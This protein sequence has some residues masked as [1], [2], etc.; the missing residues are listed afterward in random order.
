[1]KPLARHFRQRSTPVDGQHLSRGLRRD[2]KR[3]GGRCARPQDDARTEAA[4]R[5]E[6]TGAHQAGIDQCPQDQGRAGEIV[7][8]HLKHDGQREEMRAHDKNDRRDDPTPVP[9]TRQRRGDQKCCYPSSPS[10]P[11]SVG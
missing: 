2:P 10:I 1:M 4:N 5:M 6:R 3:E 7:T 11:P 8:R 9:Q